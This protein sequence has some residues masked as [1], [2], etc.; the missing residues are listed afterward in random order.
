[1]CASMSARSIYQ[2]IKVSHEK[3]S[4]SELSVGGGAVRCND[5]D[6]AGSIGLVA[7]GLGLVA[8]IRE[9]FNVGV[10]GKLRFTE[11]PMWS[12]MLKNNVGS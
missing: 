12:G 11:M 10:L 7:P 8:R 2:L 5:P 9:G 1:M 6:R 4:R 3:L